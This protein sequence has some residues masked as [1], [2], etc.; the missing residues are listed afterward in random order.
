MNIGKLLTKAMGHH[1]SG[2]LEEAE[3]IYR[4]ILETHPDEP[5]ALHLLGVAAYQRNDADTAI[6][7]IS[8]ALSKDAASP[9]YACNLGNAF[10]MKGEHLQAAEWYNQAVRLKSDYAE[11]YNNLGASLKSSG[12]HEEALEAYN[13]AITINPGYAGAL[14]NLGNLYRDLGDSGKAAAHYRKAADLQPGNAGLLFT[15]AGILHLRREHA[16]GA[17][18]YER[19]IAI[20]PENVDAWNNLGTVLIDSGKIEEGVSKLRRAIE[21]NPGS[22]EAYYNIGKGLE[23][24]GRISEALEYYQKAVDLNPCFSIA[25]NNIGNIYKDRGDSEKAISFYRTALDTFT[26]NADQSVFPPAGMRSNILLSMHYSEVI[27]PDMLFELHR[28]W[29]AEHAT[30]LRRIIPEHGNQRSPDRRLRIGY[31]SP[32]FRVHSVAYFIQSILAAHD[33]RNFEIFC[34]SNAEHTDSATG[35]FKTMAHHWRDI[36]GLSDGNVSEMIQKD[37]IDILVDLSGHTGNNR[38]TLFACKPAPVQATYLGY[39]NT[40][41]LDTVDYRITDAVADPPGRT[42]KRHSEK[43]I[44]LPDCFL[45]YRA[46]EGAPDITGLPALTSGHITFGSFNNRAKI[47]KKTVEVWSEILRKLP[48]SEL[49]IKAKSLSDLQTKDQL[50]GLFAGQGIKQGRICVLGFTES[51]KDHF[52]LYNTIDIALDTFPYNGTTTT[53]E[54]LWMGVPVIALKG[55]VHVSRVG[56]SILS[57]I[58]LEELTG[59]SPD[60]YIAKSIELAEDIERLRHLRHNLRTMMQRSPLMDAA[61]FTRNLEH[62]FRTAWKIWS[63]KEKA[64]PEIISGK[65]TEETEQRVNTDNMDPLIR[66]GEALFGSGH[67]EEARDIF[68]KV[69]EHDPGNATALNNLGTISYLAGL[70]DRAESYIA[71]AIALNPDMPSY[72]CNLGNVF[73][74]MGK[75]EE[76]VKEYELSIRLKPDFA[77][78]HNNLGTVLREL[79][80]PQEAIAAFR[81]AIEAQADYAEAF[82]NLGNVYKETNNHLQAIDSYN[83]A[84]SL[85][86]GYVQAYNNLGTAYMHLG[87]HEQAQASFHKAIQIQPSNAQA[88]NNLGNAYKDSGRPEDALDAYRNAIAFQPGYAA[89]YYN[90]AITLKSLNR[91]SDASAFYLKTIEIQPDHPEAYNNLGNLYKDQ[92]RIKD[93]LACYKKAVEIKPDYSDAHSNL[94]L[95]LHYDAPHDQDAIFLCHEDW[96]KKHASAF[97]DRV[98]SRFINRAENKTLRIGYVSPDFRVHSV[99]YFMKGILSSHDPKEFRVYCYSDVNRPDSFTK[100]FKALAHEWRDIRGRSDEEVAG[101][102]QQDKIDILI[103]LAGHTANN[104]LLVFAHKPA[105]VQATYLGYPDTTGLK[106]MDYRIT[107]SWADP[108]DREDSFCTENLIRLT[109]GFLCYDPPE[110]APPVKESPMLA[111]G[112]VTF[113]SFNHL[114]KINDAVVHTWSDLL[115]RVPDSRLILKSGSL[116]EKETQELLLDMFGKKG[117]N[118]DRITLLG[119]TPSFFDHLELYNKIDIALDTFPYNGTTTTCEAL[120]MGVPVIA[121]KGSS[122]VS[123]VSF[124]ILSNLNLAELAADSPEDYIAKAAGL[125]GDRERLGQLRRNLRAMMERSALTDAQ[126]F[127]K[128]LEKEYRKMWE[129]CCSSGDGCMAGGIDSPESAGQAPE[130]IQ[131]HIALAIDIN[132]QGEDLF[133]EGRLEDALSAFHKALELDPDNAAAHNNAGVVYW[134]TGDRQTALHHFNEAVRI[135]PQQE[136]AVSNRDNALSSLQQENQ[137]EKSKPRKLH[138]GG[139]KP[140]PDWE[141]F[142]AV[143]GPHVDHIGNAN[144]L[145]RFDDNTFDEIYSSHVLEHFDYTRE[146]ILVLKEWRRVMKPGG[147]LYVSVPDLDKLADLFLRKDTLSLKDR[148]MVMRMILGG[149]VDEYDYHKTGFNWEILTAFLNEAG[150]RNSKIVDNFMI[151]SDTSSYTFNGVAISINMIAEK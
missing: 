114:P 138:I 34:Y 54:A 130:N 117:I 135:D 144:D 37:G 59:D 101:L 88:Y 68:L 32:D 97:T 96:A 137:A 43:L 13:K 111:A 31:V 115:I 140:N 80:K 14:C 23:T 105:P 127:T 129:K 74:A 78:A 71:K 107:D 99:A 18:T 81:K 147:R 30:A 141:I 61:G 21:L 41:G 38:M 126:G 44:R 120:W 76:A 7:L 55:D 57:C 4:S 125:A 39:P 67:T 49:V 62:E 8:K 86:P 84:I 63:S 79:G 19:V 40:T 119:D 136:D 121:L 47:T 56:L 93:A 11:A 133:A 17:E 145:S 90:M 48:D 83:K 106:T 64:M 98:R 122:H 1:R 33:W 50:L 103:D 70:Y 92:G 24:L 142:N 77:Q 91:S 53:C 10:R 22:P 109:G 113:G 116:A 9:E 69:L 5:D 132:R 123:R 6:R 3:T 29:A 45:C 82:Y 146:L 27:D 36:Y 150:F 20:Q 112:H 25:W 143:E 128:G 66:E 104:R 134:Q 46:P 72:R 85:N 52:E 60:E 65:V 16:E 87:K 94:L 42:D 95:A 35:L 73:K 139:T 118:R 12:K 149:H 75:K 58:G 124:S 151:F 110:V 26:R 28:E 108:L 89:A 131:Q 100:R 51:K 102:I 2:Q 148:F 15:L